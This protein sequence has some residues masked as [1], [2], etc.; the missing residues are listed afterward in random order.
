MIQHFLGEHSLSMKALLRIEQ[1]ERFGD[2][3]A[4]KLRLGALDG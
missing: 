1:A 3:I 2:A 4:Q